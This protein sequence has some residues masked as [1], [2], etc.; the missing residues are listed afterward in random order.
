MAED[1]LKVAQGGLDSVLGIGGA[2]A[3]VPPDAQPL[4]LQDP[5]DAPQEQDVALIG[6]A[7]AAVPP[8]AEAPAPS[9]DVPS[10]LEGLVRESVEPLMDPAPELSPERIEE[11]EVAGGLSDMMKRLLL[12]RRPKGP[13]SPVSR[14]KQ[15][16]KFDV[17]WHK[18]YTWTVDDLHPLSQV[19]KALRQGRELSTTEDPYKLARLHRGV[20]AKSEHFLEYSPFR[21]GDYQNVGRGLKDILEP[22]KNNLEVI[23]DYAVAKRHFELKG[24]GI[25]TGV[26]DGWANA[27]IANAGPQA[28]GAFR[29]LVEFQNHVLQYLVDSGVISAEKASYYRE[30]NKN[31]VPFFRLMEEGPK[32]D[33]PKGMIVRDPTRRIKGSKRPILDP[34]ESIIKNTYLFVNMAERNEVGRALHALAKTHPDGESIAKQ[35]PPP[36]QPT[37]VTGEE[38]L[39]ANPEIADILKQFGEHAGNAITVEDFKVFRPNNFVVGPNQIA[40]YDQGKRILLEVDE[41]LAETFKAMDRESANLLVKFLGIPTRLL[42]AGAILSP[43]FVMRNPIRDQLSA[44]I[45][46]ERGYRPFIDLSRGIFEMVKI[47][48]QPLREQIGTFLRDTARDADTAPAT[49]SATFQEWLKSGGPMSSI[50]SLDRDYLQKNIRQLAQETELLDHFVNVVRSPV[51]A[52]R[53]LS[54][55]SERGT[56][57]GE[58]ARVTGGADRIQRLRRLGAGEAAKDLTQEGG[59]A[60]REVTLDFQRIGA[61][62]RSVNMIIAFFNASI[63]GTDKMV[64]SF[65]DHPTRTTAKVAAGIVMPSMI[66]QILNRDEPGW[67]EIPQF[68]KDVYWLIRTGPDMPSGLVEGTEAY[69]RAYEQAIRDSVWWR[70]PKPF[71]IGILFGSG[72]ERTVDWILDRDPKAFDGFLEA[73]NRGA[74]PGYMPNFMQPAIENWANKSFFTDRPLVPAGREKMMRRYQYSGYTTETA[75]ALGSILGEIQGGATGEGVSPNVIEHWVRAWSGG[76]GTHFL[77]AADYGLR[78]AGVVPDPIR[79]TDTLADIPFIKGFVVRFPSGSAESIA[80]FYETYD[81]YEAINSSIKSLNDEERYDEAD[82]LEDTAL[83]EGVL[84]NLKTFR[85]SLSNASAAIRRVYQD[86]TMTPNEKRQLIDETYVQMIFIAKDG[87]EEIQYELDAAAQERERLQPLPQPKQRRIEPESPGFGGIGPA[88]P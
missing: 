43:E 61:K 84:L 12:P 31:Y 76:L 52:L 70:I 22:Y 21:F 6:G 48:R 37:H 39:R 2:Q 27:A 65:K 81:E 57:V 29:E 32:S 45:F 56:R 19:S 10:L 77:K 24:R 8:A 47:R 3:A 28:E 75:K 46:S 62:T 86:P 73:I 54:E 74:T 44:F 59:F 40:Y 11:R 9:F 68:Q 55:L 38:A 25:E 80:Q 88:I 71:E 79:P 14:G 34:L 78:K 5:L 15:L 51:E 30:A 33:L 85:R 60:S 87:L 58:F 17:D 41:D 67:E 63:Q 83:D 69:E 16:P 1:E 20:N 13:P 36:L 82:R 53:I 49:T 50:H 72:A 42:R 18:L 26:D 64:R 7:E 4:P 23:G 35:V 66:L